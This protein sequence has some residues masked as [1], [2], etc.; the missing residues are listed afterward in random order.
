MKKITILILALS[1]FSCKEDPKEETL[2]KNIDNESVIDKSL[3]RVSFNLIAEKD[4]KACLFYTEDGTIN[5][6]DKKTIWT[7]IIGSTSEKEIV[8]TLPKD[9]LP[10]HLRIDLGRG[11]NPE[12]KYI[13]IK[14]FKIS[15]FDKEF[16]AKDSAIFNYF[17]PNKDV[18]IKTPNS[19][20][21]KKIDINQE[22][23][24]ILYPHMPLT[25]ELEKIVKQ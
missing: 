25:E 20:I 14:G 3:M 19:T 16:V 7:D 2:D 21:L 5:F 13:D 11:K 17:Y 8:F 22:T 4:D 23:A 9:V 24:V 18:N 10:T 12:Q 6:E 1:L 15:Y